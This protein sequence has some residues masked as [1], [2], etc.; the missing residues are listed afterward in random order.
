MQRKKPF[1]F[2]GGVDVLWIWNKTFSDIQRK[3]TTLE[4]E[5]YAI[6]ALATDYWPKTFKGLPYIIYSDHKNLTAKN[7]NSALL[8]RKTCQMKLQNWMLAAWTFLDMGI[9]IHIAG[10][11]NIA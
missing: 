3:W 11:N 10:E 6:Y 9:R 8:N 2:A 5:A 7:L 1:N 4:R